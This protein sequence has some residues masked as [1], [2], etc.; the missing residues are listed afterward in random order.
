MCGFCFV[1]PDFHAALPHCNLVGSRE[2][3][4]GGGGQALGQ[5]CVQNRQYDALNAHHAGTGQIT[6][7]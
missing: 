5:T 1:S 7:R 4:L 3:L 2:T 6:A